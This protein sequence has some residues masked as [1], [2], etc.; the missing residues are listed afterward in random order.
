M[1]QYRQGDWLTAMPFPPKELHQL[2]FAKP[3]LVYCAMIMTLFDIILAQG[4]PETRKQGRLI[5]GEGEAT[6]HAHA[7][8]NK[9]ADIM[10]LD[11]VRWLL[12][13]EPVEVLH[14]EHETITVPP[15]VYELRWQMVFERGQNRKVLD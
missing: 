5:I 14:E 3:L 2:H 12:A 8:T 10:V 13:P 1:K 6:G 7:V 15:G 11:N 9:E 4:E